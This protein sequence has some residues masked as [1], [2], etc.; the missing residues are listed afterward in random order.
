MPTYL[1]DKIIEEYTKPGDVILDPMGGCGTTAVEA[2]KKGRN[3]IA[4]DYEKKFC[5]LI[6]KN[7]DMA[8]KQQT[9]TPKGNATVIH[10]DARNLSSLL[11]EVDQIVFSPPYAIDPKNI[12]HTKEGKSLQDY[13]EKRGYSKTHH[14]RTGY[15]DDPDNIGNLKYGK[16]DQVIFSPPF[17]NLNKGGG[18]AVKGYEGEYGKDEKLKDRHARRL[19]EDPNNIDNIKKYGSVDSIV[20]SPPYKTATEG[21]GLYKHPERAPTLRGVCNRPDGLRASTDPE[22][23]GNLKY[24]SVDSIVMSPPHG[25]AIS[26]RGGG[27]GISDEKEPPKGFKK[28]GERC[29]AARKYSDDPNNVG[30]LP[31]GNVDAIVTSPPYAE[32]VSRQGDPEKRAE[33]MEKAGLDPKTIVGGKARCGEIDWRYSGDKKNIG[34]LKYGK[35]DS[36][37]MSPPYSE[38]IG[39]VAGERASDEHKKRLEYQRRQAEGWTEGNIAKMKHGDIDAIVTS[40]PY[41]EVMG[42]KHHSPRADLISKEKHHPVTYSKDKD[43]I[44]NLRG[45]TYL[46]A[47]HQVYAECFKVLKQG[48]YMILVV[49]NFIRNKKIVDLAGDTVKLCESVGFKHVRTH[50]RKLTQLSFWIINYRKRY[51][52]APKVDHEHVLVFQKV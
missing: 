12:C 42:K 52:D 34:N 49:K 3:C 7:I 15:S 24:G 48:G 43:N 33:R 39:H 17:A 23:I 47:M 36:V 40:P 8:N 38:G 30:N 25:G 14:G 44:G 4:V 21:S 20:M 18:I 9:L 16:V 45:Q 13:D 41:E 19:S 2:V 27:G 50:K 46:E 31:Y 10:G 32:S 28:V 6:Q 11:G 29:K 51:P 5:D 1:V 26:K 22:N 37:I 35:V